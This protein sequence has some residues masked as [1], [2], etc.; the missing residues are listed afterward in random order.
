MTRQLTA[1]DIIQEMQKAQTSEQFS[2][3][4][5]SIPSKCYEKCIT[6]P[7]KSLSSYDQVKILNLML[8]LCLVLCRYIY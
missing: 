7:S 2:L 3:L 5:G 1:D 6:K 4:M 8:E